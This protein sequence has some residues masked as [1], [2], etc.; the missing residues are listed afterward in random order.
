MERNKKGERI[1]KKKELET[2]EVIAMGVQ[3]YEHQITTPPTGQDLWMEW[4]QKCMPY[5]NSHF[6]IFYLF[7]SAFSDQE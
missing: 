2:K 3:A 6:T 7:V 4:E 1:K 5:R